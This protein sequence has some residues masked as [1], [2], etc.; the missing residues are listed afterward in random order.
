M[1]LGPLDECR[2]TFQAM[3]EFSSPFGMVGHPDVD[4]ATGVWPASGTVHR[5]PGGVIRFSTDGKGYLGIAMGR[6]EARSFSTKGVPG[7]SGAVII[8]SLA[9]V[10][11]RP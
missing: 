11:V 2:G 5:S 7:V 1:Q 10:F 9:Q 4:A 6:S 8:G 3:S